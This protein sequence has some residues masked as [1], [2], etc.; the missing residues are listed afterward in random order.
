M[1][2]IKKLYTVNDIAKITGL[3]SRTIRNYLKNG[4]LKGKKIG[5]QWRFTTEDI[6]NL[7]DK[8]DVKKDMSTLKKNEVLDFID[9]VKTDVNGPVQICT[10][11]DYYCDSEKSGKEMCD[12]LSQVINSNSDATDG[13]A[14]FSYEYVKNESKARFILF[15]KPLFIIETL[16]LL[17]Q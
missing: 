3:T 16:K 5:G 13:G 10:I 15:G 14:N 2:S 8:G 11:A 1:E 7:F 9:G 12:K 17:N 6:Q 4:N